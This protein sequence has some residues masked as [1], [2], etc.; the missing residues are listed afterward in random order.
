[1]KFLEPEAYQPLARELFDRLSSLIRQALPAA[2]IEHIDS[3]AIEGA[4]SK[5]DLDIFVGVEPEEFHDA[6][7]SIESLGF[8]VKTESFRNES[9]CPFESHDYP[10]PVGVQLVVN[11]SEFEIF[12]VF[13]D[14]MNAKADLR[15][16]Y[17]QLKRQACDLNEDEYRQ[18]KSNFIE[19]VL[20]RREILF[21]TARLRAELL[22]AANLDLVIQLNKTCSDFFL[23]QNG[24]RQARTMLVRF[25]NS[26]LRSPMERPNYRSVFFVPNVWSEL[27]MFCEGIE[28]P[29]TGIS[30]SCC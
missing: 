11:R 4:V 10:L 5:G 7:V 28:P 23:F 12:L 16:S 18:V 9:L 3:S 8:Q 29:R 19:R 21:E 30:V 25:L 20:M 15:S 27:W 17:N 22:S 2:R 24:L 13:R 26:Y 6:V 1:V 14:R